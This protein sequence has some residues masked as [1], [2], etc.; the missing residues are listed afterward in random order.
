[1]NHGA[2]RCANA[3][4]IARAANFQSV[5]GFLSI[6]FSGSGTAHSVLMKF[7]CF[8]GH[9]LSSHIST[10]QIHLFTVFAMNHYHGLSATV[11]KGCV[12]DDICKFFGY[13]PGKIPPCS[14]IKCPIQSPTYYLGGQEWIR[15]M[16]V[17]AIGL[18]Q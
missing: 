18:C 8:M 9:D 16:E 14:V 10:D 3:V 2:R 5:C 15:G 4:S 1:M 11:A 6:N 12:V 7:S 17:F 13:R